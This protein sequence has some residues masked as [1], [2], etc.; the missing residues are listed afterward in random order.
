MT[1]LWATQLAADPEQKALPSGACITKR[2]LDR[3]QL[4]SEQDFTYFQRSQAEGLFPKGEATRVVG[5]R[6]EVGFTT[7]EWLRSREGSQIGLYL[8][9][10]KGR[11]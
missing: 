6:Y 1:V 5:R 10:E 9:T 4:Q 2:Y 7:V 8:N 11:I 3:E